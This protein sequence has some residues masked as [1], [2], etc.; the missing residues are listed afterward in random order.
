MIKLL[1]IPLKNCR[2]PIQKNESDRVYRYLEN[3]DNGS[4]YN[5][6]IE[7]IENVGKI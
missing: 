2:Q 1:M 4:L 5:Y 6:L 7:D 3:T